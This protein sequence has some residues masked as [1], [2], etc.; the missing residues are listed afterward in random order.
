M[1]VL[2]EVEDYGGEGLML[3][4]AHSKYEFCRSKLL[5]K[6][7][8]FFD[9]EAKVVGQ[10]KGQGR[11]SNVMGHLICQTPDGREFHIGGGFTDAQRRKPPKIGSVVTYKYFELSAALK[12]RFPIFVGVRSD[13]DWDEY[14]K[15]YKPPVKK[16][17]GALKKTH[18]I[19]FSD[20]AT[21]GGLEPSSVPSLADDDDNDDIEE[22]KQAVSSAA[23]EE[24]KK[25]KKEEEEE[26]DK[27][28]PCKYGANCYRQNPAHFKLFSHPPSMKCPY[29]A[30][31]EE[32]EE[33]G[34]MMI[35]TEEELL[36]DKELS[37]LAVYESSS[38]LLDDD[39]FKLDDDSGPEPEPKPKKQKMSS[40]DDDVNSRPDCKYGEKCYNKNPE[41]L[42]KYKHPSA[43]KCEAA[44]T[45]EKGE[46][47]ELEEGPNELGR[48]FG[49]ITDQHLSRKQVCLDVDGKTGK[50]VL[51]VVGANSTFVKR[52]GSEKSVW[53]K[54]ATKGTSELKNGDKIKLIKDSATFVLKV[55]AKKEK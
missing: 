8:T 31:K 28:V 13:I 18:T 3:R 55:D 42:K 45:N 32:K 23:T 39:S 7:K 11:N 1:K 4:A 26:E 16:T 12:P 17:P 38:N 21:A 44:L 10:K 50:V 33:K 54:I 29:K 20:V 25:K 51:T 36:K 5:L 19:M 40:D 24:K 49:G 2:G 46:V 9:E 14:C 53:E 37:P 48:G 6:V 27:R 22:Y 30:I 15:T 47:F 34:K 35:S 43:V 52:A 41:H